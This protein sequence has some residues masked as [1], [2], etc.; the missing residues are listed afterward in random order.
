MQPREVTALSFSALGSLLGGL[1]ASP[2]GPWAAVGGA[3][4]GTT[5][6][7]LLGNNLWQ[8]FYLDMGEKLAEAR[9]LLEA[10]GAAEAAQL[11]LA[12]RQHPRFADQEQNFRSEIE[13]VAGRVLGGLA[14]RAEA[15]GDPKAAL[16]HYRQ[17]LLFQPRDP[18]F[19]WSSV[20]LG[21][22]AGELS[23]E[24]SGR[25]ETDLKQ[26]L[27]VDPA[28]AG[29]TRS[30]AELLERRGR[31]L[32]A[33][34]VLRAGVEESTGKPAL[35]EDWIRWL[36]RL[37]PRDEDAL[38]R[39]VELLLETGRAREALATLDG[40]E[41][42]FPERSTHTFLRGK[43]LH[44]TGDSAAARTLLEPLAASHP[45][46]ALLA[47]L[48]A[49]TAGDDT[50]AIRLLSGV[51]QHPDHFREATLALVRL[52]LKHGDV[53]VA[54][55]HLQRE[56]FQEDPAYEPLLE[57]LA[58]AYESR[59]QETQASRVYDRMKDLGD[60]T[61]FWGRF[62]LQYR[63]GAPIV[64]GR[65]SAGRVLLG[66]RRADGTPVAIREAP[67]PF[68]IGGKAAR[69]FARE[70]EALT[71]L[72]HPHL[73]ALFGHALPEA[74]CLLAMEYCAGG[75]LAERL[76]TPPLWAQSKAVAHSVCEALAHLH[77][78]APPLVHRNVK[79]SNVLYTAEGA[80]KL[81]DF[82]MTRAADAAGTSVVTSI[83]ERSL[84]YLYQS[85]EV[86]LGQ[87]DLSP[88]ADV[89]S[90]GCLLYHL[91]TGRPPFVHDDVNRQI[92][93]H[94]QDLPA[95]PSTLA[96][97]VPEALDRVVLRCLEKEPSRR[98]SDAGRVWAALEPI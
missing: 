76:A 50:A 65:G 30:L 17:A 36:L 45:E 73:V 10:D 40:R 22:S 53:D 84:V 34:Q 23:Y 62:T 47:G 41:D 90:L 61:S 54:F 26:L 11:L 75:S 93:A 57:K 91:L 86:I 52:L 46:A 72:A 20:R 74:K 12:L 92:S 83:K 66:K 39:L 64:L 94:F 19:L 38:F 87:A 8:K 95:A 48:G 81:S 55:N 56:G 9:R 79:P 29:A 71:R 28:H 43:A 97:W 37:L 77:A 25:L 78:Q 27:A 16:E 67:A 1:L 33:A 31:P 32:E 35:R 42:L 51:A 88:A 58:K 59:G 98:Y 5:L 14:E 7:H 85:P 15:A 89:Y 82:S 18:D 70:V 2:L 63:E 49:A 44:A 69:R 6:G 24:D 3:T 4:L 13:Y 96:A 80:V 60:A 68:A 21:T